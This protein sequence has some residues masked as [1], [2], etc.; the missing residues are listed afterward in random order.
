MNSWNYVKNLQNG[1]NLGNT[2][3]C[4]AS[5]ENPTPQEQETAWF[6][7]ITTEPMI[8]AI[9]DMGFKILRVPVTWSWQFNKQTYKI[10]AE[11]MK[12]V[13]DVV[14]Y[15]INND[16]TV[17]LNLHHENWQFPSEE[18]Y[19]TAKKILISL[20]Q[21]IAD[22][23]K[24]YE[25]NLIFEAMNEPRKEGTPHEWNGGDEE[26]RNV[27]MKLNQHFVDTVRATGGNNKTRMLMVPSYAASG[28]EAAI[29]DFKMP[30]GENL[31]MSIHAYTP[32]DFALSDDYSQN[33]WTQEQEHII[34][35]LFERINKYFLS[36]N[37]PVIMG[38]CGA[39]KK[40]DNE[41]DRAN[42]AKYY[43]KKAKEYG[44]PCLWWDNG[45]IT[46]WEEKGEI[47]GILNRKELKCE[48]PLIVKD[49]L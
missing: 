10:N 2:L 47:F 1:W 25:N 38:E 27:V 39:R 13:N 45:R 30:N 48:Y 33:M 26:G 12:R 21:Q 42:W 9:K 24:K 43:T 37:I 40:G 19:P 7:P 34:D 15:G 49:F 3:D 14:D 28:D 29:K 35:E 8:K 6:N 44:V 17:I 11:W 41:K 36:K 23:F 5:K 18:N 32:N 31:I 20:W 22:N 4:R 46:E 16:M